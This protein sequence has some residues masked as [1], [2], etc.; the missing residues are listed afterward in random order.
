MGLLEQLQQYHGEGISPVTGLPTGASELERLAEERKR[1][2]IEA[3]EEE[4]MAPN[5]TRE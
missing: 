3:Y 5:T 1:R 2:E 4:S